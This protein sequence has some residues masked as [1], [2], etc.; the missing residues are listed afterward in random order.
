MLRVTLVLFL[1]KAAL[2]A[3]PNENTEVI[4]GADGSVSQS[5]S[6]GVMR[7]DARSDAPRSVPIAAHN[8]E[9]V[10]IDSAG[11][12][13]TRDDPPR[14]PGQ[15]TVIDASTIQTTAAPVVSNDATT[16][17]TTPAPTVSCGGHSAKKCAECSTV[18]P[19][20]GE[21]SLDRGP[22]WCHGDCIYFDGEC[23]RL[24]ANNLHMTRDRGYANVST[25]LHVP[26]MMNPNI[27]DE[28]RKIMDI[29]ADASVTEA[30]REAKQRLSN[31]MHEEKQKKGKLLVTIIVSCSSVL[32]CCAIGSLIALYKY[33]HVGQPKKMEEPEMTTHAGLQGSSEDDGED[34]GEDG[35]EEAFDGVGE[36]YGDQGDQWEE[37]FSE[38]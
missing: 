7:R 37:E 20:T 16:V 30:E 27:T 21:E 9:L 10:Q 34:D 25:T 13:L 11:E 31:L 18:N 14:P 29:A 6:A 3:D 24:T 12:V 36:D 1:A 19:V 32:F 38:S 35:G 28:D 5:R 33:I 17:K 22:D 23:H 4:L 26:D 8:H 15:S 2:A